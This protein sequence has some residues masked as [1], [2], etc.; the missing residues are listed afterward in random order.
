MFRTSKDKMDDVYASLQAYLKIEY[1]GE[2]NKYIVSDMDRLP[3][4]SINLRQPYLTQRIIN[5]I[6]WTDKSSAKPTPEV[7]TPLEKTQGYQTMKKWL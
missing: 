1:D 2:L 4:G 5:I 7:K 6:P 3:Y